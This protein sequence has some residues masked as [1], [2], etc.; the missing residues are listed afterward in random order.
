MFHV[1]GYPGEVEVLEVSLVSEEASGAKGKVEAEK[2]PPALSSAADQQLFLYV[3]EME[4]GEGECMQL[5]LSDFE[6]TGTTSA[7]SAWAF[8]VSVMDYVIKQSHGKIHGKV[9]S[10]PYGVKGK[11]VAAGGGWDMDD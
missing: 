2:G 3:H 1:W 7:R 11:D 5:H 9:R 10:E 6:N 4:K 8:G